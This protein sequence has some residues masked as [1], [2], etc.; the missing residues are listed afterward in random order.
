MLLESNPE[1][2]NPTQQ[3]RFCQ[4]RDVRGGEDHLPFLGVSA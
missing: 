3:F 1:R 2:G 4:E